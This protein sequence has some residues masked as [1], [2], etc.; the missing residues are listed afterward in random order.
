MMQNLNICTDEYTVCEK[1]L[2]DLS[3]YL[4]ASKGDP[5][6]LLNHLMGGHWEQE[7]DF[8]QM[9]SVKGEGAHI[10]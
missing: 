4:E 1:S 10:L 6:A 3:F 5:S 8:S 9:W 2:C 7:Q